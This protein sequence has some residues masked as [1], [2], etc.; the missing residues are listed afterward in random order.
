MK[1]Q[2]L[3]ET[4]IEEGINNDPRG[5]AGVKVFLTKTKKKYEQLEKK[6]KEV[7]DTDCLWNPYADSR[8]LFGDP[9]MKISTVM[10][11]IDME[12]GEMVMVDRLREQGK[13]IDCVL[14]HHP[15]GH[16][17]ARF[18]EVMSLQA[19]VFSKRGVPIAI[20]ESL[21]NE[22]MAEV[23]RSVSSANHARTVDA[24]R[25][26]NIPLLCAHTPV[27]NH[28]YTYLQKLFDRKKPLYLKNV[29]DILNEQPEYKKAAQEGTVPRILLGGPEGRA[30]KI[31]VDMTGGTEGSKEIFSRLVQSGISTVVG[32]HFTEAHFR[33]A[34]ESRINIIN[35]GHIS[36]DN[37]GFNL[38]LDTIMKKEK[39]ALIEASGFR[40]AK[41][42]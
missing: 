4:I 13:K 18:Y 22:R 17:L 15:D 14:A 38:L 21:T 34:K 39:L 6:Q 29:L 36:S 23:S 5:R 26:L 2:K 24:A 37:L 10:V 27:D 31:L 41:R 20:A 3:Y 30:G 42:K 33:K 12:V 40:R 32:M 25:L 1:L 28:V 11:G 16:A 8:L 9:D 19:D 35:A 7:F